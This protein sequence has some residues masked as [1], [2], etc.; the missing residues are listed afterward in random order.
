MAIPTH[1][2]RTFHSE[3]YEIWR[4]QHTF[5]DGSTQTYERVKRRDTVEILALEASKILLL[6][7][8]K[9][10]RGTFPNVP[11]G[12]LDW[13]EDPLNGAQRE[14][15]EETGRVS[16]A[17]TQLAV[18]EPFASLEWQSYVFIARHC[19]P[20]ATQHLEPNEER[21]LVEPVAFDEFR[22]RLYEGNWPF[23]PLR[24]VLLAALH[25][26][27]RAHDFRSFLETGQE[28]AWLRRWFST[29]TH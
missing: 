5:P 10:Y 7:E 14:L 4:W 25:D 16:P 2:T 22:L 17:W 1:A 19:Q 9:L 21:I 11:A 23:S 20:A 8:T 13:D 12:T 28:P 29:T 27:Q 15:A 6:E 26:E 3:T 24:T 18:L